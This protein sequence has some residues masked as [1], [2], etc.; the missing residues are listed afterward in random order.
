MM[1]SA[2]Y[3]PHTEVQNISLLKTSLLLW[4][5]LHYIVPFREYNPSYEDPLVSDAIKLIGKQHYPNHQEKEE[6]HSQIEALIN[7]QLPKS[8]YLSDREI[9]ANY[10]IW[11]QKLLGKTWKMLE[12]ARLAGR[13]L[14]NLDYP[15]TM[16][17]GLTVM[18]I[19]ADC[20]AGT[21]LRRVTDRAGA[22]A[23][24]A[25]LLNPEPSKDPSDLQP[26]VGDLTKVS[27]EMID[28]SAISLSKLIE[29]RKSENS[30]SGRSIRALRHRYVEKLESYMTIL[31]GVK[32][33]M[34]DEEEIKRQFEADMRDDLADL[35]DALKMARNEVL[36][37][38]EIITAGV[39]ATGALAALAL[40]VWPAAFTGFVTITSAPIAVGG[41]FGVRNKYLSSRRAILE[42][43]PMAYLL[44]LE[45]AL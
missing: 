45:R 4:D 37:S 23:T 8:F 39:A 11:P 9:P 33:K 2:L 14:E 15:L 18:S 7:R 32:G 27:L 30:W 29:F 5:N 31:S 40:G 22:Y 35:R 41:L 16:H 20:C 28:A 6:A 36:T 38:R 19:L 17:T 25:G 24:V 21:T 12:E 13:P 43:H 1:R 34:A 10:Q 42:K 26:N 3:Y 44:E